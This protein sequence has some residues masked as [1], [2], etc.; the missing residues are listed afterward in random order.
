MAAT[1]RNLQR[2]PQKSSKSNPGT[3][4]LAFEELSL[5]GNEPDLPLIDSRCMFVRV[6]LSKGEAAPET[7]KLIAV[8]GYERSLVIQSL[9]PCT[10]IALGFGAFSRRSVRHYFD[11]GC[12][13]G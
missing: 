13:H 1:F 8:R 2:V 4:D 10:L 3:I 11:G 6:A 7:K 12:F 5:P 9:G